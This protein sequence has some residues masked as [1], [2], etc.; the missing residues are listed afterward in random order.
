MQQFP[1]SPRAFLASPWQHRGLIAAL[2]RR[3]VIGRYQGSVLGLA[4]SFFSPLLMLVVYTFVFSE[5]LKVRWTASGGQTRTEFAIIL[6]AGLIVF[7]LFA[8]CVNRA[9]SLVLSNPN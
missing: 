4:W 3:E 2:T 9:P 7:G 6:F 8:E 5:V 1:I